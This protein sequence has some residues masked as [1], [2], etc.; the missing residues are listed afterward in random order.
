MNFGVGKDSLEY[1]EPGKQ[2]SLASPDQMEHSDDE[3]SP[4]NPKSQ[5]IQQ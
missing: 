2:L 3:T 5:H 1:G 4:P